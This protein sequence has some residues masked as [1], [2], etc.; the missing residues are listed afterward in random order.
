LSNLTLVE[1]KLYGALV[2]KSNSEGIV[3]ISKTQLAKAIGYKAVGG[4]IT[5]ALATL[6]M[7][8]HIEQIGKYEWKVFV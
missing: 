6:Q 7:K 4:I 5:Y 2:A 3:K 1:R 8:N